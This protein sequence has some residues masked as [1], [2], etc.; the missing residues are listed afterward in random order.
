MGRKGYPLIILCLA[1]GGCYL[2]ECTNPHYGTCNV[3]SKIVDFDIDIAGTGIGP[4]AQVHYIA[5]VELENGDK[6]TMTDEWEIRSLERGKYYVKC[7]DCY[8]TGFHYTIEEY[9]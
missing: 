1:L 2:D 5:T 4:G 9:D 6:F 8:G 7:G 3:I